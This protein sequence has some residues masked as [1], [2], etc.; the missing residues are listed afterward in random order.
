MKK[1]YVLKLFKIETIFILISLIFGSIVYMLYLQIQLLN[2]ELEN[3]TSLVQS[4]ENVQTDLK[5]QILLR[6]QRIKILENCLIELHFKLSSLSYVNHTPQGFELLKQEIIEI[7]RHEAMDFLQKI[8]GIAIS[9]F[10]VFAI[11]SYFG[12]PMSQD[13]FELSLMDCADELICFIK[14]IDNKKAEIIIKN[15]TTEEGYNY[16][17]M[18]QLVKTLILKSSDS[19]SKESL[20]QIEIINSHISIDEKAIAAT[21]IAEIISSFFGF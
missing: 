8:C 5:N 14:I 9:A 19:I 15:L 16:V 17:Y 6:N 4:L 1:N 20:E 10:L 21:Q 3:L 18:E 13:N 7:N 12:K 11:L 2:L